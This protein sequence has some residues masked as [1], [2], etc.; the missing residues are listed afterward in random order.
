M[1]ASALR[2]D[3]RM[4]NDRK[5]PPLLT[6]GRIAETIGEPLHRVTYVL[7]TR[8][9]I[10][11]S[12]TAGQLRLYDLTAVAQIRHELNAIDARRTNRG[13]RRG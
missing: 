3:P 9:Y 12:A 6:P 2:K 4:P 10:R 8:G 5:P 1:R 7:R 11:P 13:C